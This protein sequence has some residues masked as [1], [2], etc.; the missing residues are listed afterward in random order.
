MATAWIGTSGWSY[1]HWEK[2]FYPD[3][4]PA[5]QQ[6]PFFAQHF[7]TV[8]INY[9]YPHR[10]TRTISE[11]G[12]KNPPDGFVF[13]V[14]ASRY[15]THMKK[16]KDPEEPLERLLHNASGLQDKL[17][18]ILFQFPRRWSLNLER[19]QAFFQALKKH[20][21]RRYAFEFR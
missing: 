13:A 3:K 17:G 20:K 4:L 15:L 2:T 19:L 5:N 1:K 9:P 16:L 21:G 8:E 18:P 7:P 6:L 14:K 12:R 11:S 10:R